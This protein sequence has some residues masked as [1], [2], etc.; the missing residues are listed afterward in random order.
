MSRYKATNIKWDID[1]EGYEDEKSLY[2]PNEI[3][4]PDDLI[5]DD[6]DTDDYFETISDYISELTGFCHLGFDIENT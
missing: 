6:F 2:L 1:K 3:E 5:E 4:I